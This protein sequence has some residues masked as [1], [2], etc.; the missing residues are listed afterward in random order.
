MTEQNLTSAPR[1]DSTNPS[2]RPGGKKFNF[3]R[4]FWLTF[5]VASLGYAW[6]CY[7]VP[8][9]N[10]AWSKDVASAKERA[11]QMEKP[12]ILFFTATWCVPC[13]IM[14]REV[15]AD[16][17]V[18]DLVNADF[19]AV[20][21]D[22]DDPKARSERDRYRITSTPV[23]II[24]DGKGNVLDRVEGGM[25]KESFLSMLA[26]AKGSTQAGS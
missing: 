10:V 26:K 8:S 6:Y 15:W 5:L 18:E 12:T 4:W 7:Y 11:V 24:V 2:N 17:Q 16:K 20:T 14:K 1:P 3:W 25:N 21:I 23:T 22:V 19:T 9:N 13:R